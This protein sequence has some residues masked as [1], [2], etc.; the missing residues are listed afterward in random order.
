MKVQDSRDVIKV[1]I[2]E[3]KITLDLG[4]KFSLRGC[5]ANVYIKAKLKKDNSSKVT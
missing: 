5:T 3:G 4:A 1:M 2:V